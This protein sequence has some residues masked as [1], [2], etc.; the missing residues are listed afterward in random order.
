MEATRRRGQVLTSDAAAVVAFVA[1]QG[2]AL[3]LLT[4]LGA[5]HAWFFGD[6]WAFIVDRRD[7]WASGDLA[8]YVFGPHNEHWV[9]LPVLW[10]S[11]VFKIV[12]L[13]QYGPYVFGVVVVHLVAA[14][15]LRQLLR[16]AGAGPW[17]ATGMA[18]AF[19]FLGSGAEN[20]LWGFQIG[21]AGAVAF[22]LA[23]LWF[24]SGGGRRPGW[25]DLGGA[26][27]AV[28]ALMSSGPAIT[29]V[30]VAAG[31]LALRGCW[32]RAAIAAGAPAAAFVA[33]W[34]AFARGQRSGLPPAPTEDLAAFTMRGAS[35]AVE[36]VAGLEGAGVV[37]VV[38][39][40]VAVARAAAR[41]APGWQHSAAALA[42]VV[43]FYGL[44]A[45]GRA[46][47]GLEAA[48]ASRYVHTV[49]P[50]ALLGVL[51]ALLWLRDLLRPATAGSVALV[52]LISWALLVNVSAIWQFLRAYEPVVERARTRIEA[53]ASLDLSGAPPS[54]QPDPA[55]SPNLTV[56]ALTELLANGELDPPG[57]VDP[58]ARA[59]AASRLLLEIDG[60]PP[61]GP[62]VVEGAGPNG[63]TCRELTADGARVVASPGTGF[64]LT[65]PDADVH[66]VVEVGGAE[67]PP[68]TLSLTKGAPVAVRVDGPL[69]VEVAVSAPGVQLCPSAA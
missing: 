29:Y 28:G 60:R 1:L 63:P 14:A 48:L 11:A 21:F 61:I 49:G 8:G 10:Y 53:A 32:A 40:V 39:A 50:L 34:V 13:H 4:W 16:R 2:V 52:V 38:V 5:R 23:Q 30:A 46:G 20:L 64:E 25:A 42:G 22:G 36:A 12:G 17:P 7:R 35:H 33:W 69:A 19:L 55:S 44:T 6:E 57:A 18:G 41:H 37:L 56:A 58:E 9:T 47:L 45:T 3:V 65:G 26:V 43:L 68:R 66:L 15:L 54:A 24:V 59:E 51:P 27:A 62:V 31:S 67:A